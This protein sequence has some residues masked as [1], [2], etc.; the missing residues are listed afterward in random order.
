MFFTGFALAQTSLKGKITEKNSGES[1]PGVSIYIPDYLQGAV[2]DI[3]GNYEISNLR[4]GMVLV[5]FSFIGY[6]TEI[7]KINVEDAEINLDIEMAS[8]V[9]QSDEVVVTGSFTG[10][11][12][13]NVVRI[14][15]ISAKE[16]N[17]SSNPSFIESISNIPGVSII[18][19]GPGIGT[20]VIRGLS[21][22]N[23][24]VLNNGLPVENYQF[25]ENHPFM[26]DEYGVDKVEI[27]KGPASLLYGSGA[28]GGVMNIIKSPPIP[29]GKIKGDFG[30]KYFTNT[31]GISSNL[32]ICGNSNNFLWG[33]RGGINSNKDYFDGANSRIPNSRF[34]RK[35]IKLQTG[36][37]QPWGSFRLFYDYNKDDLGL[38]VPASVLLVNENSRKNEIWY[39]DLENH[40][41]TA[42]NKFF[43][44]NAKIDFNMAFQ[45]NHRKLIESEFENGPAV[46][47]RL[48]TFSYTL[49]SHF[50]VSEL[51]KLIAGLQGMHQNNKNF[52]APEKVLPDADINDFS[53]FLIGQHL[54]WNVLK[55]EAGLR[56]DYRNIHVPL[57]E[58]GG[59][60]EHKASKEEAETIELNKTYHNLNASLGSVFEV[61]EVFQIRFNMASAFRSPNLAE[62][63][64]HGM[65]GPRFEEGNPDLTSQR[66]LETDLDFHFH[67]RHTTIDLSGFYNNI[68]NYI[69][70]SPTNDTLADGDPI[71]RY[72]QTDARIYGGEAAVHI[73]PHPYDWLHIKSSYAYIL[74]KQIGGG[75]L[76]FIPANKLTFEIEIQ[77]NSYKSL[78][79]PFLRMGSTTNFNQHHPGQFETATDG[80]TLLS[81]GLGGKLMIF[82]QALSFGIFGNNLLNKTYID[83]L[84]TLKE[85]GLNNMGRNFSISVSYPIVIRN[86]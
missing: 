43:I 57:Q 23:I 21:L 76:P 83:H 20:P 35:S 48:N 24:I 66:S 61:N 59:G 26:V 10:S 86:N 75:F 71:Y 47:M 72:L 7:R 3:N 73:H 39:Q 9:I 33:I 18:S 80:Y 38:T 58:V 70:L 11:Q 60:H 1:L 42:M 17:T 77:F 54:Y 8:T 31:E 63:T 14:N 16:I 2:S 32:G 85:L 22:S 28:V 44:G 5:Q 25:S 53:I 46:D 27:I 36:L 68:F 40:V 29:K 41:V 79:E 30:I 15:S 4:K 19:K 56:Y 74:G 52:E 82:N 62:L 69:F 84:S 12:H 65:H 34:N 37:I 67:T 78:K 55:I 51:T 49:K 6:K 81:A 45:Q 50:Q 64:Q 13:E